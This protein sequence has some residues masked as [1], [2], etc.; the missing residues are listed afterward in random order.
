MLTVLWKVWK[1]DEVD[2][3][4][5]IEVWKVRERDGSGDKW[6]SRYVS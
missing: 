1:I 6:K 5:L 3:L 4:A 2:W